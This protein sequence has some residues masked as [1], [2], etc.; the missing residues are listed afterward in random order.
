GLA[1][2]NEASAHVEQALRKVL[3]D[4]DGFSCDFPPNAEGKRQRV[5][6]PDLRLL[7]EGSGRVTYLDPKLFAATSAQ[8][9]LRTFYYSPSTR[10]G[11]ILEDAHHLLLGISHDG[12]DGAWTFGPWHLVDL[13]RLRVGLKAEFQAGNRDLYRP[14]LIISSGKP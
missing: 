5:G 9:S 2:I 12:V 10:T 7:H 6:Y 3:D 8:S 11:K 13:T 4:S 1:R 14:D